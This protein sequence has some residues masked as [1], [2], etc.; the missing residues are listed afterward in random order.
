MTDP[1]GRRVLYEGS[2]P[3]RLVPSYAAIARD[4]ARDAWDAW[5]RHV[6]ECG[7]D[8]KDGFDCETAKELRVA[9]REARGGR[10]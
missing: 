1:T 5:L 3:A 10:P 8:C 7:D 2:G 6:T 9:L 4:K